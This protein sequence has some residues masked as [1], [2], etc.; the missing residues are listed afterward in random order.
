M[1]NVTIL[2]LNYPKKNENHI[3]VL[4]R[5]NHLNMLSKSKAQLNG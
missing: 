1:Y 5:E 2:N 4:K 3:N